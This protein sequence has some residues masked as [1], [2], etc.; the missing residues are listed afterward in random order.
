MKM[1]DVLVI[2]KGASGY[3]IDKAA[4]QGL[5]VAVVDRP[6]IGGTCM[7][8]GCVPSK[9]LLYSAER[10]GLIQRGKVLGIET[11]NINARFT[12]LLD[13]VR[14][15]RS[16]NRN[17]H[18]KHIKQFPNID[19]YEVEGR[20]TDRKTVMVGSQELHAEKIFIAN[21][22][23]PFIPTIPGLDK[24]E[25]LT[26]E[27][28]LE[29]D[30]KPKDMMIIGGGYIALEY[31]YFFSAHGVNV[32]I[33]EKNHG[34]IGQMEPELSA[35]LE[36]EVKKYATLYLNAQVVRF[37]IKNGQVNAH[38]RINQNEIQIPADKVFIAAG[39][40]SNA[41]TLSLENTEI[42]TEKNGYILVDEYLQTTQP[43]TWAFG[44]VIGKYMFKH[45]ANQEARI[46]WHNATMKDKLKMN[47][48][49]APMALFGY[50]E[51]A[52]VGMTEKQ[53]TKSHDILIGCSEYRGVFKGQIMRD[54]QGF[55]KAIVE[56][57]SR[58][59]LGFHIIGPH[60]SILLQEAVNVI[61]HNETID[62]IVESMHIFPSLS[63][64]V[65]KPLLH[66]KEN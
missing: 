13:R 45:V 46:V 64:L 14:Q 62:F 41:D 19:L 23:R 30:V 63:E 10:I 42:K 49:A 28:I 4:E 7:N 1:Y 60:A 53:A 31:A 55:V 27:S 51:V 2:G 11:D 9:T 65:L 35:I 58:K 16:R 66:L 15:D 54:H 50:P 37:E 17:I 22:A 39:R 44:D 32:S 59:L 26:N 12:E 61:A 36:R 5:K 40:R 20:F 21:G 34:L 33:I 29:L 56:K 48:Y 18:L 47:Y 24:V 25:F 57:N 43:D 52:S 8:F 6:P 3:V 38:I